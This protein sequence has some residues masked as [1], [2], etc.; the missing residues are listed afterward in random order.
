MTPSLC[1][2]CKKMRE[3]RTVR[4]RFVLCQLSATN[5]YYPKSPPQPVVRSDGYERKGEAKPD[6]PAE[7]SGQDA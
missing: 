2:S 7:P 4:S 3:V 1:E 6:T 5:V